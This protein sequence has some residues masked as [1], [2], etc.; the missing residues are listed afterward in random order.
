MKKKLKIQEKLSA[1]SIEY[2]YEH[3]D[4]KFNEIRTEQ[5]LSGQLALQ[6][7]ILSDF[8]AVSFRFLFH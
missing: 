4:H 7:T 2:L 3:K 8:L 1:L 6:K 5:R